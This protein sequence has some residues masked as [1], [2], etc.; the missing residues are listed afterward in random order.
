M[1]RE[2]TMILTLEMFSKSAAYFLLAFILLCNQS[3][4]KE[5]IPNFQAGIGL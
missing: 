5:N 4:S 3:P 1:I 2:M